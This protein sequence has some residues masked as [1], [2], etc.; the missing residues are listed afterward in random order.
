MRYF[1]VY[2]H[3]YR[4]L[5]T[6]YTSLITVLCYFSDIFT[7]LQIGYCKYVYIKSNSNPYFLIFMCLNNDSFLSCFFLLTQMTS[8][9]EMPVI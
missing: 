1:T 5:I 6:P 4:I 7:G 9:D 8:L 2:F 3:G